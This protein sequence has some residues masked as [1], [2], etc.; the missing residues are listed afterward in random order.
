M[1]TSLTR[2]SA[3]KVRVQV[4]ATSEEVEPAVERAVRS[5]SNQVKVPGFRKGHVPRKVLETRLGADALRDAV[6][7]EAI[8]ELLQKAT[9]EETLAPIAPPQVEVTTYD[10][11]KELTF[12]ATI[13]VRPEIELPDFAMLSTTRPSTKATPE[14]IDDQLQRMQDRFS[15]L[16]TIQRPARVGDYLLVDIHT[17]LHG[18]EI[19]EL[20]GNDQLYELGTAWPVKE[21]DDELT[22]KR[23]GDI[24]KFNATIPDAL[25]GEHAGKE[26]T[27]QVLVKEVREKKLPALDDE[28]AKTSSEFETLDELR[29]DLAQRIEKVKAIQSDAEVRNRILEQVLDDVEVEAPDSLV[30]SEMAYRLQRLEEQLRA[31]GMTLDQYLKAQNLTEGQIEADLR[32]Q[33]D[34]N[35]RAQLILEEIGRREGFQVSEDELREEVRYHAETLRTD[36]AQLAKELG[37]RGRLMAIAGDIIRRKALNLLV[38]RAEVKDEDSTGDEQSPGSSSD[39]KDAG[40]AEEPG[41]H[42]ESESPE[43]GA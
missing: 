33:A 24:V 23:T 35:V 34:R 14:E 17:T 11:G 41:G 20:S 2:D 26:V 43:L 30:Q 38:E 12:E 16:E 4:E 32:N 5:L 3:S 8:P 25:G 15:T 9:D 31:A 40:P 27:F 10:L 37:E 19:A 7:R 29:A 1:K 36:P 21:L 18:A 6:L 39:L 42:V 13:E 28:F 22:G